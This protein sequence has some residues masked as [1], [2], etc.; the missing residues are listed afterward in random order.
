[1]TEYALDYLSPMYGAVKRSIVDR[2]DEL[3]FKVC[4]SYRC[5]TL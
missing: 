5:I 1:M 2:I 3:A 4:D